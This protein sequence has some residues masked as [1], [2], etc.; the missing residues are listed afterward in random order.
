[1]EPKG[2]W[3]WVDDRTADVL[4][5]ACQEV[6]DHSVGVEEP[7]RQINQT[8]AL[9]TSLVLVHGEPPDYIVQATTVL[10]S[11]LHG[12]LTSEQFDYATGS[13]RANSPGDWVSKLPPWLAGKLV[14]TGPRES[15]N[16]ASSASSTD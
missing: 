2:H 8:W 1:L 12:E 11:G 16:V 9:W 3:I 13:R 14:R 4:I 6:L 10:L 15:T 5:Q 7:D